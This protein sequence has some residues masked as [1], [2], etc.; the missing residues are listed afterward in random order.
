VVAQGDH[1]PMENDPLAMERLRALL[2][3]R[4]AQY[5]TAH[6]TV[7]TSDTGVDGVVAR[8]EAIVRRGR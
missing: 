8:V 4:E 6:H 2:A 1:R 5:R 3:E 7:D